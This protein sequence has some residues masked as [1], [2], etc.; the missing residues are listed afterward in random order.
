MKFRLK[1][2]WKNLQ[3]FLRNFGK[4]FRMVACRSVI[5]SSQLH[6]EIRQ[7]LE[8]CFVEINLAVSV[9]FQMGLRC[10]KSKDDATG[11]WTG[12]LNV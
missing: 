6:V 8:A 4:I 2:I 9:D 10:H 12:E 5:C 11:E 1:K 3:D 7:K